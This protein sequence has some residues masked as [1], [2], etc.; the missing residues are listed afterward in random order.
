MLAIRLYVEGSR[1]GA[2][3]CVLKVNPQSV[4]NWVRV[5]TANLPKAPRPEKVRTAELDELFTLVGKKKRNPHPD[6][7]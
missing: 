4:A 3:G 2:L 6:P 7:R 5:Y 1:Y